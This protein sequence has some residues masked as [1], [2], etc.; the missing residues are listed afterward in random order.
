VQGPEISLVYRKIAALLGVVTFLSFTYFYEGG[1]WNQNSRFDFLRAIVEQH[2]LQIDAFHENT[3]DKAHFNGHYYSDKAPGL[4]LLSVPFAV[5]AR[6]VLRVAGIDPES[7]RGEVALSYIVTAFAVALPTALAGVCLFFL[8]VRFG[9]GATGSAFGVL[10]M[11]L[12]TPTFCGLWQ[13]DWRR[14]NR[15]H[16][17]A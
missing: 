6:P 10:V 12:G 15:G 16:L 9:A 17:E 8:G 11:C 2:T 14:V 13:W 4:V 1:G 7:P 5:S 3:Q